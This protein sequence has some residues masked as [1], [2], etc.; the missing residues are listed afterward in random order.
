MSGFVHYVQQLSLV[1]PT[2]TLPEA[3]SSLAL[4]ICTCTAA[5]PTDMQ[6]GLQLLGLGLV[7]LSTTLPEASALA[8]CGLVAWHLL[9]TRRRALIPADADD[10]EAR[11][12]DPGPA[13][14]CVQLT[15]G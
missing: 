12:A 14:I 4:S 7:A 3:S 1:A 5:E 8:C 15:V 6:V 13:D 9:P 10:D 2:T 11:Y